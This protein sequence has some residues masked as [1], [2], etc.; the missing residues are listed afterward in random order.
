MIV[1][2]TSVQADV[3][4]RRLGQIVMHDTLAAR[5]SR[6]APGDEIVVRIQRSDRAARWAAI[7]E[8]HVPHQKWMNF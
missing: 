4:A 2:D 1:A 8:F 6:L 7:Q 5:N 3:D